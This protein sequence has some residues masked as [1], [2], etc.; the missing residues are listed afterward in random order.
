[1]EWT[2][3]AIVLGSRPH[4]EGS[5]ILEVMTAER[6][7]HMG[8]VKGGRGR[9][10][11]AVLQAG[12]TVQLTWRARLDAHLGMFTAELVTARAARLMESAVGVYGVQIIAA[13]LR[14]LAERD[15]HPALYEATEIIL[16]H[17]DNALDVGRLI[18]R[19][20]L[21][22]LDELGFGL[23]LSA[24]AATGATTDLVYV[25]PKSARAVS[26]AAG[27]PY[28]DRML[29]L[30]AFLRDASII[31]EADDLRAAFQLTG[32]FLDRHVADPR[33]IPLSEARAQLLAR[34]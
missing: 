8:L 1:M 10:V 4:G 14:Y 28:R 31:P 32:Y 25:S 5:V 26:R 18:V 23:D 7:R 33:A 12:N 21:A 6:G 24:C 29:P 20:E 16:D 13:H 2:S 11:A 27:E 9:R 19:F 22:L 17:M 34:I 15:P 30:P 3:D